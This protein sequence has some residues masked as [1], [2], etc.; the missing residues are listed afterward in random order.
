M[1]AQGE[2]SNETLLAE[3]HELDPQPLDVGQRPKSGK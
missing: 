2:G 1:R 3:S